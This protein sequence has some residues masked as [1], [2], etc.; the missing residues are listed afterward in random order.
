[1]TPSNVTHAYI[2]VSTD[3]QDVAS[4]REQITRWCNRVG[5]DEPIWHHDTASGGT[6]WQDRSLQ[7]ILDSCSGYDT[8]VVSEIS[9]IARSTVGVLTFLQDAAAKGVRVHAV[10]NNLALDGSMQSQITV[11]VLA[12]CADIE[13]TMLRERTRAALSARRAAGLP[14]GRPI[15]ARSKSML[16][17][18][19]AEIAQLVAANVSKRAIARVMQC[20]PTT[21]HKYLSENPRGEVDARQIAL[22]IDGDQPG[23]P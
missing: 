17:S 5:V 19:H 13:R 2:R 4:Q 7:P 21:L 11:T 6:R 1:M 18:R 22:P 10:Q 8:I 14:L 23:A 3:R 20:S 12:L 9:R 16:E 15:G